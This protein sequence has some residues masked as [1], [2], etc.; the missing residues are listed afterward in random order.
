M[1]NISSATHD[2]L[3]SLL[4]STVSAFSTHTYRSALKISTTVEYEDYTI[5][6]EDTGVCNYT[7]HSASFLPALYSIYFVLGLLGNGL[8]VWVISMGVR[9]RSMTD[10]CLLNLAL[11]DLLLVSSLPFLAHQARDKWVF[12]DAM[13]KLVLS[14]YYV[15]YYSGIYFIAL[16]GVD[17]YLAVVHAIYALQVRTRSYGIL[18]SIVVWITA[19]F[20]SFPEVLAVKLSNSNATAKNVCGRDYEDK[21]GLRAGAIFKMNVLGFVIPL[22]MLIFCYSRILLTLLHSRSAKR[23][24]VRLVMVVMVAF[25]FCWTPYN[26]TNFF[27]GLHVIGYF[28]DCESS[29]ALF[30]SLQI[31]EVMAYTHCC[32]NPLL[33]VFVGEK[34]RRHLLRLLSKSPCLRCS[35]LKAYFSTASGS[36]Y[37][38][39]RNTSVDERSTAI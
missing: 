37:S 38:V 26:V 15:G 27:W 21:S 24:A 5:D 3:Q 12:G 19:I 22:T 32:L 7:R 2:G 28:K 36:V 16:M 11:A 6:D 34:F 9:L 20:S 13:C 14:V 29:N 31:T 25:L 17:R 8:V 23:Q 1:N 4:T 18:A 30:L 39:S 33:Y 35:S 10:V